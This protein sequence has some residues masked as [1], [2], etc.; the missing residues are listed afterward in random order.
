MAFCLANPACLTWGGR[1]VKLIFV[2]ELVAQLVANLSVA[3]FALVSSRFAVVES[4]ENSF[5]KGGTPEGIQNTRL[6]PSCPN[7]FKIQVD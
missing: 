1:S 4:Q 2:N 6:K 3:T 5:T 7:L